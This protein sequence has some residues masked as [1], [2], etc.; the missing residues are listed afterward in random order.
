MGTEHIQFHAQCTSLITAN[1]H[2]MKQLSL[3]EARYSILY[4]R[5][6]G[7]SLDLFQST[8]VP[9]ANSAHPI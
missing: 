7:K 6:P 4:P 1:E 2:D 3:A 5:S 8:L 9:Y